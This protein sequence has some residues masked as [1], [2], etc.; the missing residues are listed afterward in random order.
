MPYLRAYNHFG[1]LPDLVKKMREMQAQID[2]M[3][4]ILD[5][6]KGQV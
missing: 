2:E 1:K 6:I 5:R 4:H 3:Q